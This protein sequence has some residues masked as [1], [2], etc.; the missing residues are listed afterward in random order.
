[1][2]DLRGKCLADRAK[3]FADFV[4]VRFDAYLV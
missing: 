4:Q 1:M 2:L 3:A